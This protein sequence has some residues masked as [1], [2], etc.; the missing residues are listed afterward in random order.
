MQRQDN[1]AGANSNALRQHRQGG[2]KN[3][4]V[5]IKSTKGMEMAFGHPDSGKIMLI[6]KFGAFEKKLIFVS[7]ELRSIAG[8]IKQAELHRL[9]TGVWSRIEVLREGSSGHCP[10][11]GVSKLLQIVRQKF[12]AAETALDFAA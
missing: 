8:K 9:M 4:W 1:A 10:G 2:S 11:S 6:G 5:G 3:R 12:S 7:L